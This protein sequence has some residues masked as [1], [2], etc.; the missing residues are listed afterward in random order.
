M[1]HLRTLLA[2]GEIRGAVDALARL[3]DA[4]PAQGVDAIAV[5]GD[6]G[7]AWS[8]PD[9]YRSI[10]KALGETEVPTFWVPGKTDAPLRDYLPEAFN[11]EIAFPSLN[12]VHG[13]FAVGPGDVFFAG[14]GGEILDDPHTV[15]VEEA[16]LRYPAREVEYRL[17]V[18]RGLEDRQKVFLFT[19]PPAHKGTA[20]PGSQVLAELIKTHRPRVAVVAGEQ[21]AEERL[22]TT[23]VVCP[24]RLDQGRYAIVD[25]SHLSVELAEAIAQ[26]PV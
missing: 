18:F 11:M 10:F 15:K 4:G 5:V 17:K 9:H 21:P 25:F 12:A 13:T 14:V 19:T 16:S 26:A 7:S 1:S 22:G 8:K 24:G 20:A 3:L 6:L 23:L 2:L